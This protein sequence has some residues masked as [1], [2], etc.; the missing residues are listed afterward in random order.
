MIK[1]VNVVVGSFL[2][3]FIIVGMLFTYG[4][5]MTELEKEFGWSRTVLSSI[6]AA[7][8]LAWGILAIPG[9]YLNDRLGPRIV[10]G[11]NG[12]IFGIGFILFSKSSE[13]WHLFLI[14]IFFIGTGS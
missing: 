5:L 6:G 14:F 13:V 9:G 3:Q 11:V 2:T 8:W 7:G 12:F 4:V 10:L 1:K